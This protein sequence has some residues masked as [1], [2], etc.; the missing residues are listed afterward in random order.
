ME[1]L[2]HVK[3]LIDQKL[4]TEAQWNLYFLATEYLDNPEGGG[5]SLTMRFRELQVQVARV[6]FDSEFPGILVIQSPQGRKSYWAWTELFA[7]ILPND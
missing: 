5:R 4:I 6:S 1:P 3:K 2:D 7:V